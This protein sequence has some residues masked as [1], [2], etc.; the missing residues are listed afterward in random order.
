[1]VVAFLL[2]IS[3]A[4]NEAPYSAYWDISFCFETDGCSTDAYSQIIFKWVAGTLNY[5]PESWAVHG[6]DH[7]HING[8]ELR[9][10]L[11]L[12]EA[13]GKPIVGSE[14]VVYNRYMTFTLQGLWYPW[15]VQ[16]LYKWPF[17]LKPTF[18]ELQNL[19]F[20]QK[21]VLKA[22]NFVFGLRAFSSYQLLD[23]SLRFHLVPEPCL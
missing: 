22:K 9:M 23:N 14:Q 10:D 19:D 3:G 21:K 13:P 18:S 1:M 7:C 11:K 12:S 20:S 8:N 17:F 2:H 15:E 4:V 6:S 5:E 16:F